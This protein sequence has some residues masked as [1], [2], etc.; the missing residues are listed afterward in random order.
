[1]RIARVTGH[2]TATVKD[3]SLAAMRLLVTDIEDGLGN[4]LEHAVVAVDHL[5]A[6]PGDMVL[7][8]TGSAARLPA[9]VGGIPVDA[10]IVAIVDDIKIGGASAQSQPGPSR[11]GA[12]RR[13]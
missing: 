9:T 3:V 2:V 5:G 11:T 6:G 10:T 8:V 13:K 1:M 12:T 7:V 4:V